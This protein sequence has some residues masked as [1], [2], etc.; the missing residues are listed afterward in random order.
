MIPMYSTHTCDTHT[1]VTGGTRTGSGS[2]PPPPGRAMTASL[3]KD[4]VIV[5]CTT[6]TYDVRQRRCHCSKLTLRHG[7]GA[8][9]NCDCRN[10][11]TNTAAGVFVTEV[12]HPRDPRGRSSLFDVAKPGELAGLAQKKVY[13]VLYKNAVPEGSN[14]LVGRFVLAIKNAENDKE[15]NKAR[16]VVQENNDIEKTY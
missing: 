6:V 8:D 4:R 16:F 14:I 11:V 3:S 15:F 13:E 9:L 10:S 2:V 5:L 1:C 12:L 7:E